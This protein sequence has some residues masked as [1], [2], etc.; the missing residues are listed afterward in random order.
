MADMRKV[1]SA[2]NKWAN[3]F[4]GKLKHGFLKLLEQE[5]LADYPTWIYQEVHL[6]VQDHIKVAM[7]TLEGDAE[8]IAGGFVNISNLNVILAT[9]IIEEYPNILT[10]NVESD[11][12]AVFSRNVE[13]DDDS[14]D[15]APLINYML[16]AIRDQWIE[17]LV[18]IGIEKGVFTLENGNVNLTPDQ[19]HGGVDH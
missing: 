4:E 19:K 6:A 15:G 3:T 11:E 10:R 5:E 2:I 17:D 14:V 8:A 13:S 9:S 12:D 16:I 18:D 7:K 1:N